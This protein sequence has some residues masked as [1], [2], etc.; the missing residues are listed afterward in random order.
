MNKGDGLSR[1]YRGSFLLLCR[2]CII[3]FN[4]K[5]SISYYLPTCQLKASQWEAYRAHST[6][7]YECFN[8]NNSNMLCKVV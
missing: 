7:F 3:L 5:G 6:T 2:N 4:I 1:F 8:L